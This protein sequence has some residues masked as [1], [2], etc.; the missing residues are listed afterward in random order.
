M[1][2]SCFVIQYFVSISFC[3]RLMGKNE[4]VALL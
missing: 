4:S 3:N 2:G 1:F